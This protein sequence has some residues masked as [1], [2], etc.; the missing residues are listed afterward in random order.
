M[1]VLFLYASTGCG[2]YKAA[3]Y[4]KEALLK[5]NRQCM[6]SM[7]DVLNLCNYPVKSF[8]LNIFKMLISK[9]PCIY[10]FLYRITENNHLFNSFAGMFFSRSIDELKSYCIK[11]NVT[12]IVCTH[13]LALL[14]ASK[15]K[16][17]MKEKCPITVGIITDYQ[18][19]KFWLYGY[20]DLYCVPNDEM[21]EQLLLLG[22]HKDKV[23]VTGIPCPV[24]GSLDTANHT[25]NKPYWLIAGG[26]WGLGNLE[27]TTKRL[28]RSH[29]T[30]NLVVVAGENRSL[31]NRLKELEKKNPERLTVT[32]T[33]PQ[34]FNAMKNSLAVLTKP[35]GLTV[36]E[37]MILRKPLILLKPLP[38]AEQKNLDYLIQHGAAISFKNFI[39]APEIINQWQ[40]QHST[41]QGSTARS[42]SS[43]LIAQWILEACC[44][45]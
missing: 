43:H 15:L 2:H 31:Y 19:H 45:K 21:E 25:S 27:A 35:G 38:G 37:A 11:E 40:Y 23:K 39:R 33:L 4:V 41:K 16:R 34:L 13:P 1:H 24:D 30:C 26:G 12:S 28:L 14:F 10:R 8:I 18:I 29:K 32:G 42:D 3:S 17:E 44:R 5:Q 20:I 9:C 7:K 22:W 36:T 6:V